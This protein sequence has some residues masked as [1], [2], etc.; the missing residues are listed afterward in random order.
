[1]GMTPGGADGLQ[2]NSANLVCKIP[3]RV[4]KDNGEILKISIQFEMNTQAN[5]MFMGWSDNA[6]E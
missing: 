6:D 2:L 5:D 1:M 4:S 3:F